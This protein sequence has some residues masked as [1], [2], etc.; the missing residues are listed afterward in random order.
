MAI[1]IQRKT[2][3]RIKRNEDLSLRRV[4]KWDARN[5]PNPY[6][7]SDTLE[8]V[9]NVT[10]DTN[11]GTLKKEVVTLTF[12]GGLLTSISEPVESTIDTA[13]DCS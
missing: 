8:V 2:Q 5:T 3:E 7:A 4:I 10:W 12:S 6:G 1:P 11:D 9:T 13:E